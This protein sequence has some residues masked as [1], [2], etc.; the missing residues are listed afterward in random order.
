MT[1]AGKAQRTATSLKR[2]RREGS[3]FLRLRLRLISNSIAATLTG[4]A[5]RTATS[6]KRQR[7]KRGPSLRLSLRHTGKTIAATISRKAR[8][9]ARSLKRKRMERDSSLRL[10]LRLMSNTI[11][12]TARRRAQSRLKE[13]EETGESAVWAERQRKKELFNAYVNQS[14]A[15]VLSRQ[16][17]Q[18]TVALEAVT[19][20]RAIVRELNQPPEDLLELRN[21]AIA[22]LALPDLV[23][24]EWLTQSEGADWALNWFD[25]DPDYRRCV[26]GSKKG[27]VRIRTLNDD[28]SRCEEV[29]PL[30]GVAG[31]GMLVRRLIAAPKSTSG[32]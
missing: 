10:R 19:R 8:R 4:M 3:P 29:V 13:S 11:A 12:A 18:R 15:Q 7:R 2:Q 22:A 24:A 5:Q 27:S 21:L 23:G 6:L 25:V 16:I 26:V 17:G 30:G 9:T 31:W 14:R 1:S 20:A 32:T 28:R